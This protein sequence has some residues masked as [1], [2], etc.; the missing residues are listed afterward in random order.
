MADAKLVFTTSDKIRN[1]EEVE[2][3]KNIR[4]LVDN[5]I[6][7]SRAD[8]SVF[9]DKNFLDRN[10]NAFRKYL[11]KIKKQYGECEFITADLTLNLKPEEIA[12]LGDRNPCEV[13]TTDKGKILKDSFAVD[14]IKVLRMFMSSNPKLFNIMMDYDIATLFNATCLMPEY[15]SDFEKF[16]K[17]LKYNVLYSVID[18][19]VYN[20]HPFLYKTLCANF[21]V[22]FE[23]DAQGKYTGKLTTAGAHM[24][25]LSY[26]LRMKLSDK[27]VPI[28]DV[29]K[30]PQILGEL[31]WSF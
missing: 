16:L 31:L 1:P 13:V 25:E 5:L 11:E 29:L 30:N 7:G 24:V 20:L 23:K 15:V 21:D 10:F 3:E 27:L 26:G 22:Y 12:L 28:N 17:K 18:Y 14:V 9:D 2:I 8:V 4:F 19:E 6:V